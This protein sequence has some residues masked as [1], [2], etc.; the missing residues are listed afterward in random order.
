MR[1]IQAEALMREPDSTANIPAA[2]ALINQV[3]AEG[4]GTVTAPAYTPGAQLGPVSIATLDTPS[5]VLAQIAHERKYELFSQG[6]RWEDLRRFGAL[7]GAT[8]KASFLPMPQSECTTNP[9]AG[10]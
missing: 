1:L 9:N 3:R 5:K 10:C 6:L 2:I 4:S 8:P 7:A